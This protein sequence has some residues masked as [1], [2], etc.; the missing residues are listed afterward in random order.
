MPRKIRFFLPEMPV[1]V[2][3]RG[4]N[5]EPVFFDDAD[6]GFYLNCLGEE[7]VRHGCGIHAYVLMMNHIHLLL[8]PR[9][10][11]GVSALMQSLGRRFVAYV[12]RRHRRSG[13][14]WEG[15]F[16]ACPVQP[17]DHLL[18]CYCYIELNPM[19]A[20][21]VSHPADYRWSS[22][23][24]N[25]LA[26]ANGLIAPHVIYR[27]LGTTEDARCAGYR[28]LMSGGMI[29]EVIEDI[30]AC[31]QTGTPFGDDRFRRQIEHE[32]GVKVGYSTRGR[33]SK[34][35]ERDARSAHARRSLTH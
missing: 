24:R 1:H 31:V 11:A 2:L 16:K 35:C 26:E 7:A 6:C 18:A 27:R 15:R 20:G 29:P 8:T 23:G 17:D 25:A 32:L 33:P 10:G 9:E 19:R 12:N 28:A 22:Y 14:L 13:T 3:Q 5:R 4:N 30:R 34:G 21:I